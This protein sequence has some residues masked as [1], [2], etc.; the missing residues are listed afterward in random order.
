M[1][2]SASTD[3]PDR[4]PIAVPVEE[5]REVVSDSSVAYRPLGAGSRLLGAA[6]SSVEIAWTAGRTAGGRRCCA[7][8]SKLVSLYPIPSTTP[9]SPPAAVTISSSL[10]DPGKNAFAQTM[11]V[12]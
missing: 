8:S 5:R 11:L 2:R 1:K 6:R 10:A 3:T 12:V 7:S 4:K 9:A